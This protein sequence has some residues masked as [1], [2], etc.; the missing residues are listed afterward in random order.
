MTCTTVC[1]IPVFHE[2]LL[3]RL[4]L[5]ELHKL[6]VFKVFLEEPYCCDPKCLSVLLFCDTLLYSAC[7]NEQLY[8]CED[9]SC[10][11][12]FWIP[13]IAYDKISELWL[14]CGVDPLHNS[15]LVF[16]YEGH[17]WLGP[18]ASSI[19]WAVVFVSKTGIYC[20]DG[21]E[22]EWH[23]MLRNCTRKHKYYSGCCWFW[24][25][26]VDFSFNNLSWL[27]DGLC[28][29]FSLLVSSECKL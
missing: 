27:P 6:V 26:S 12:H 3:L 21:D 29:I 8:S 10:A 22:I 16:V 23:R 20:A 4:V 2:V 7:L 5:I 25:F 24:D 14:H 17:E 18:F 1:H 15:R 13:V 28:N 11:Y 19:S 9:V